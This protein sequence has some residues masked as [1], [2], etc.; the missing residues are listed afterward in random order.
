MGAFGVDQ[1]VK[2]LQIAHRGEVG[3][4]VGQIKSAFVLAGDQ[5]QAGV[6]QRGTNRVGR[7]IPA[8]EGQQ[9]Y[10]VQLAVQ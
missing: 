5:A 2:Q 8:R 7:G 1:G 3:K 10:Q 4:Q 9:L 6:C